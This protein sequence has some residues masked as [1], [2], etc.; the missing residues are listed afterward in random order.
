MAFRLLDREEI[1][2]HEVYQGK[3]VKRGLF[4]S[5]G[6]MLINADLNGAYNIMR[7]AIPNVFTEGIQGVVPLR[8]INS[9]PNKVKLMKQVVIKYHAACNYY[10]TFLPVQPKIEYNRYYQ[11]WL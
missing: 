11:I 5:S 4:R 8:G 10:D 2:K 7:K 3:K 9:S 6:G 1:R